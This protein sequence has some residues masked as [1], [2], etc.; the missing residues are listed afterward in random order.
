MCVESV[1]ECL[2]N[3]WQNVRGIH[4][5]RGVPPNN[6][7]A[8]AI[9]EQSLLIVKSTYPDFSPTFAHE[10]LTELHGFK[11][12]VETLRKWMASEGLWQAQARKKACIHPSRPRRSCLGELIQID[13]SPHAWFE[14]R[15]PVCTLIVFI[16]DATSRLMALYFSPTE[17]TYAYMHALRYHMNKHGRPVSVYSDKHS[18]FRVNYPDRDGAQTQLSRALKTL[19]IELICANTPQAKGRVERANQ[20]LQDR[21]VKEL[22]LAKID[23][24]EQ[25]NQWL[26]AFLESHNKR[27]AIEASSSINAHRPVSFTEEEL[28]LILCQQDTRKLSK[29]LSMKYKN[30]EYQLQNY[31]KGYRYR[32]A[33]VTVCE[34]E[35][36]QVSLLYQGQLLPYKAF[37]SGERPTPIA[38]EKSVHWY[39]ERAKKEQQSSTPNRPAANHPWRKEIIKKR[40]S[41]AYT[42]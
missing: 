34:A 6:R 41:A 39:V 19:D 13:G 7:I 40:H 28:N 8:D 18:I 37:Q 24:I 21:L 25:A 10:K 38:D 11:F 14:D 26:P 22:R 20:T 3:Q 4:S 31:G 23:S 16:D 42:Q 15:G 33:E 35:D 5:H 17:T 30:T 12:S 36:G 2:W 29:N 1:A 27:F 32:G 9:R